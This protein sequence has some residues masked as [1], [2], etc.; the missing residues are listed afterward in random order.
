MVELSDIETKLFKVNYRR[1]LYITLYLYED[2][3]YYTV[4][5]IM[6]PYKNYPNCLRIATHNWFNKLMAKLRIEI[7]Y[8]FVRHQNL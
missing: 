4:Y 1:R 7:E 2:P 3:T 5:D 8:N 6:K